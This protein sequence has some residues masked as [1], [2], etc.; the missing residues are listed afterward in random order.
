MKVAVCCTT[1]G[2]CKMEVAPAGSFVESWF[3][4]MTETYV[5]KLYINLNRHLK[6][7]C[8]LFHLVS[9]QKHTHKSSKTMFAVYSRCSLVCVKHFHIWGYAKFKHIQN[10]ILNFSLD[11]LCCKHGF[12]NLTKHCNIYTIYNKAI[13]VTHCTCARQICNVS[14]ADMSQNLT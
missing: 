12:I 6:T 10:S 3:V 14:F 5:L 9:N 13:Y 4:S 1:L 7:H 2:Y 11:R 8:C